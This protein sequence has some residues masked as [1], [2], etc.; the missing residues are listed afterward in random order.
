M[1]IKEL[2]FE[3]KITLDNWHNQ[4]KTY[5][6][7]HD[8]DPKSLSSVIEKLAYHNYCGWHLHELYFENLKRNIVDGSQITQ[9]NRYRNQCMEVVDS[10]F[11]ENQNTE[12]KYHS[13]G[14][15][16]II[17]RIINDYIKYLHCLE[18]Q[19]ERSESLKK[20]VETLIEVADE[21]QEEVLLGQ[22]QIIIW[23][24]FKVQYE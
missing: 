2:V 7:N 22:K 6:D 14:F 23:K 18:I 19:D 9:H 5:W 12:A 1:N 24:R 3:I 21:L 13:E 17:D 15:G 10:F 16:S 11:C 8:F 20:Q 4:N